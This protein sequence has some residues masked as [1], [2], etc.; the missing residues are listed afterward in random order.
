MN[1]TISFNEIFSDKQI[2]AEYYLKLFFLFLFYIIVFFNGFISNFVFPYNYPKTGTLLIDFYLIFLIFVGIIIILSRSHFKTHFEIYNQ[3]NL[4]IP[5]FRNRGFEIASNKLS[6]IKWPLINIIATVISLAF[7]IPVF[8]NNEPS[9]ERILGYRNY[10]FYMM[11]YFFIQPFLSSNNI[12]K[13][14]V[15]LLMIL[16][17]ILAVFSIIQGSFASYLPIELL[18]LVGEDTFSFYESDIIRTT[19]LIGNTIIFSVFLLIILQL[20][21]RHYLLLKSTIVLFGS[22]VIVIAIVLTYSRAAIAGCVLT[23]ILQNYYFGKF[24]IKKIILTVLFIV[25]TTLSY[26]SFSDDY[27]LFRRL[28]GTEVSTYY[29][30]VIHL[31]Q[32]RNSLDVIKDNPLAGIGLGSQGKSSKSEKIITDG[33]WFQLFLELGIPLSLLYLLNI[34]LCA[35]IALTRSRITLNPY[36]KIASDSF[37]CITILFIF[38]NFLN[39]AFS[40]PIVYLIYWTIFGLAIYKNQ[41]HFGHS[42]ALNKNLK[43]KLAGILE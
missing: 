3:L 35:R 8:L 10:I 19:A 38:I 14:V 43:T 29:S 25:V 16:G 41:A 36:V 1:S 22:I 7:V 21:I 12:H 37:L 20:F 17:F 24:N 28:I 33:F 11:I 9:I 13:F 31:E 39:S 15:F 30:T 26:L 42:I 32:I 18:V 34:Y 27:F 5:I 23:I 40:S 2:K 4:L 6:F